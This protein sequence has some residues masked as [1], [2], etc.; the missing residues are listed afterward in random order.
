[1]SYRGPSQ[2]PTPFLTSRSVVAYT[3]VFP[4]PIGSSARL[5]ASSRSALSSMVRPLLPTMVRSV[6][7]I[8][9][10]HVLP[11]MVRSVRPTVNGHV[12]Q[13]VS[14]PVLSS[15]I[16]CVQP[17]MVRPAAP[18]LA[19]PGVGLS[20]FVA[21]ARPLV[22]TAWPSSE[23][24]APPINSGA[25]SSPNS[26]GVRGLLFAGP[27]VVHTWVQG[28]EMAAPHISSNWAMESELS[29]SLTWGRVSEPAGHPVHS[30]MIESAEADRPPG[31]SSWMRGSEL[32]VPVASSSWMRGSELTV[33]GPSSSCLTASDIV[34]PSP[35]RSP[36]DV[37]WAVAQEIPWRHGAANRRDVSASAGQFAP[38]PPEDWQPTAA[39]E[40]TDPDIKISYACSKCTAHLPTKSRLHQ[41][42]MNVHCLV[43]SICSHVSDSVSAWIQHRI[44][45]HSATPK[46][47]DSTA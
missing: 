29:V 7:P 46:V 16:R 13:A 38:P 3:T 43:C 36:V 27:P 23:V 4:P 22:S 15:V 21:T 37:S 12:L 6:Q 2:A 35:R 42:V 26:S 1:M 30:N 9:N 31:K 14:R 10:G 8:V 47:G 24:A 32:T 28:S 17:A 18:N 40:E 44:A 34:E 33:P 11:A 45:E 5:A 41:H 39:A 25:G 20:Q 19:R